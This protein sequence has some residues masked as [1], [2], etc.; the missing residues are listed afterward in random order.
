MTNEGRARNA[1]PVAQPR[2]KI[3]ATAMITDQS[4]RLSTPLIKAARANVFCWTG[5]AAILGSK[6]MLSHIKAVFDE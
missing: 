3:K 1:D 6:Y 4:S 5:A 2:M